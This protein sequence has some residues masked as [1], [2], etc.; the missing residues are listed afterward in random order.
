M[1]PV[2]A[3]LSSL[4]FGVSDYLG[5]RL[6]TRMSPL[7]VVAASQAMVVPL[8]WVL[9]LLTG[10]PQ[11]SG[12]VGWGVAAGL[13]G[14]VGLALFY[15]ALST[16]TVGVVAPISAL[17]ALLPVTVAIAS[18][19]RPGPLQVVGLV[20]SLCGVVLA[21]GPELA[22]G[23]AHKARAV[24]LAAATAVAFGF[25]VLL[26][27]RGSQHG[28]IAMMTVMRTTSVA[29]FVILAV[30]LRSRGGVTRGHL[31]LLAALGIGDVTANILLGAS[32]TMGLISVA[33][34]LSSLY[35]IVTALLAAVLLGERMRGIQWLGTA[36]AVGGVILVT[37]PQA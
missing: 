37:V 3:L 15:T 14:P 34:V 8:L 35:P 31:P 11:G 30:L 20:V 24:W 1:G 4:T 29:L 9:L 16:G 7:S 21:S 33:V 10:I 19:E 17:N 5:G 27:T 13:T 25:T 26:I 32:S 18:G 23:E 2:L 12:Y 6:A 28:A 22:S 36:L